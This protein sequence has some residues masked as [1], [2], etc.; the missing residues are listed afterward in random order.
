MNSERE[1]TLE[2]TISEDVFLQY[3]EKLNDNQLTKWK[4]DIIIVYDNGTRLSERCFQKKE[5]KSKERIALFHN[6]KF[7]PIVRTLAEETLVPAS[8][9]IGNI[10]KCIDRIFIVKYTDTDCKYRF[11]FNK[12]E[13]AHGTRFYMACEVEYPNDI[14]HNRLLNVELEM[15]VHFG[16]VIHETITDNALDLADSSL[17]DLFVA[18]PPKVQMWSQYNPQ[19]T[20]KWAYKWN[21]IKAKMMYKDETVYIW[22]D[23]LPIQTHSID[24]GDLSVIAR[25][26]FQVELTTTYLIL[27]H[28]LSVTFGNNKVHLI[29]PYSSIKFLD[30]IRPKFRVIL[31]YN[32]DNTI[33]KLPIRVQKFFDPPKQLTYDTE[34]YD[35]FILVQRSMYIKW[36]QPTIDAIYIGNGQFEVGDTKGQRVRFKLDSTE[37]TNNC[38]KD[39]IYELSANMRILRSRIDRMFCSTYKEYQMFLAAC[40]D[41]NS[42][43]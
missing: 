28:A 39:S 30:Y 23:A 21:G 17:R 2:L 33:V 13:N 25:V 10:I 14:D 43:L 38:V 27:V 35:G 7:Y 37:E 31:N 41:K 5:Y 19:E 1:S 6:N 4:R 20:Y 42:I 26:N 11:S 12:A 29:E 32:N 8:V 9:Q 34:K 3:V 40:A 22:P 18:T 15:F 36:K 16:G 24:K